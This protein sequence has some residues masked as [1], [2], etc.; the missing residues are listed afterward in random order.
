ML[1]IIFLFHPLI[2]LFFHLT[3]TETNFNFNVT[4]ESN[5]TDQNEIHARISRR[6][7]REP[8]VWGEPAPD[9][10]GVQLNDYIHFLNALIFVD[11]KITNHYGS[12]M[13]KVKSD[14]MKLIQEAN[15]YFYQINVRIIVLDVLQTFRDDLSLYSFEEYRNHRISQLP[16]HDFAALISYRYAGGLAF[17]NGMCTAK[18]VMLCGFYP[19]NPTAMGGI[20]FHEVAHLLGVPHRNA[21]NLINIPNCYCP[22]T[23]RTTNSGCLKIPGYDHDCTLQQ[24]VNMLEKNR[25]LRHVKATNFFFTQHIVEKSSLP[26]CGN[27]VIEGEEECDCGLRKLCRNWNCRADECLQIVKTWQMY[28]CAWL[29]AML[30]V[31][32]IICCVIRRYLSHCCGTST[33]Y[34][35]GAYCSC[36]LLQLLSNLKSVIRPKSKHFWYRTGSNFTHSLRHTGNGTIGTKQHFIGLPNKLDSNS[37]A[38]LIAPSDKECL[39]RKSMSTRPKQPPPPPPAP[40]PPAPPVLPSLSSRNTLNKVLPSTDNIPSSP[41]KQPPPLPIKPPNLSLKMFVTD[42]D[43]TYEMPNTARKR[44]SSLIRSNTMDYSQSLDFYTDH[45]DSI[46]RKFDDDFDDDFDDNEFLS[47]SYNHDKQYH[48]KQQQQQQSI[49]YTVIVPTKER[50]PIQ[51]RKDVKSVPMHH[52]EHLAKLSVREESFSSNESRSHFYPSDDTIS[53]GLSEEDERL[54]SVVDIVRKFNG[55]KS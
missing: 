28:I 16:N 25:C 32:V 49:H 13:D 19:N 45:Y 31:T 4:Y 18:T 22:V 51:E 33:N 24:M 9:Y 1:K 17:V 43:D 39:I 12:D 26:L 10:T 54:V 15:N 8:A 20:F 27:G 48:D 41:L 6:L 50:L 2:L 44:L 35:Y 5:F 7:R 46:S 29:I 3:S 38:I 42:N 36:N 30:I 34:S 23:Q 14:V 55:A 52:L 37:I 53:T 47:E 21:T 40:A 11:S